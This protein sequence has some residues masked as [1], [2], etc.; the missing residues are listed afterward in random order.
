M[1]DDELIA[2]DLAGDAVEPLL[3]ELAKAVVMGAILLGHVG[4]HRGAAVDDHRD[5]PGQ[6]ASLDELV[7]AHLIEDT[8]AKEL[9]QDGAL[10]FEG[11]RRRGGQA[12]DP[13]GLPPLEL[14]DEV[15]VRPGW[16]MVRFIDDDEALLV[17]K[18]HAGDVASTRQARHRGDDDVIGRIDLRHGAVRAGDDPDAESL[19][20]V[21]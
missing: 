10:L 17:M 19:A 7:Q 14:L 3:A 8:A 15:T 9:G 6:D 18:K 13:P 2:L 16:R 12:Q 4:F 11:A 1:L 20:G 5:R 21:G